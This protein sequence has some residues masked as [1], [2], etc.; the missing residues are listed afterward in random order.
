MSV[1]NFGI[2]IAYPPTADLRDQG[3]GRYLASFLKGAHSLSDVRFTICCPSWSHEAL[4]QLFDSEG[5]PMNQVD[6]VSPKGVPCLLRMFNAWKSFKSRN[7]AGLLS[8]I[9][10]RVIYGLRSAR[11]KVEI[12]IAEANSWHSVLFI[13]FFLFFCIAIIFPIALVFYILNF[14]SS[15][16]GKFLRKISL[17]RLHGV[18]GMLSSPKDDSTVLRLFSYM[19]NAESRRMLKLVDSMDAV[20]AWYC[21]TAFWPAFHEIKKPRLMC[22]PDIVLTEFPSAFS[23]IGGERTMRI[24]EQIQKSVAKASHFV[25]YSQNVKWATLVDQY[26]VPAEKIS[27]INHA[28]SLLNHKVDVVGYSESEDISLDLCKNLLFSA[29]R[30]SS[31]PLYTAGFEN[32]NVDYLFYA[33]QFRPNK[34]VIALLKAY[35]YLLRDK[36][37]GVK[38]VLTGNPEHAPEIK[39]FISDNFLEKDVICISGLSVSE[40]A[41]CYKMA[42]LAVNPSLSEGG[43]PFTFTEALSVGTPVVASRIAVAEEVLTES[44]LQ[45]ATFF[46]PYDWRDMANKIEWGLENRAALLALQRPYFD[47]LKKRTWADVVSE[48]INVLEKISQ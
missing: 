26:G 30:K 1:K 47:E 9:K 21:P 10:G 8:R 7:K 3:L 19:E 28:P 41:A 27:V 32:W 18:L 11:E 46:D 14:L 45:D 4:D 22:M 43:C 5:V 16:A 44:K 6:I 40:L 24:F 25:T 17:A 2:Y 37:I 13:F 20:S 42:K 48:H 12:S 33:S 36:Y 39:D 15:T 29:F 34:N 35:K 23:R 31:N 38:L